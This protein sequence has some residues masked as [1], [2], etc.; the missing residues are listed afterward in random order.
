MADGKVFLGGAPGLSARLSGRR[1]SLLGFPGWVRAAA[2]LV[3]CGLI[4]TAG[5]GASATNTSQRLSTNQK[6]TVTISLFAGEPDNMVNVKTDLFT[7][8]VEKHFHIK[9]TFDLV[10]SADVATKQSLVLNSGS[11]PA[12]IW[13]GSIT[14]ENALQYGSERIFVPLNKLLKR[15]APN[16]WKS[17]QSVPGYKREVTAPN[18]QIY[19]LPNVNYCLYCQYG[20]H[21]WVNIKYLQ[22][23]GLSMPKTTAQ[24][25]NMLKVFKSHGLT[26]ITGSP[27]MWNG[28]TTA[29]LMNAFIPY[30]ADGNYFDVNDGKLIFVPTQPQWRAGL[31]YIHSLYAKGYFS[32]TALT[33]PLAAVQE[34]EAKQ[35]V[36]VIPAGADDDFVNNFGQ[37]GTHSGD[38][39]TIP[40]LTGP[41]GVRSAAL[42]GEFE[43]GGLT[44][45]ITNK[46]TKAQEV[47]I[48]KLLNFMYTPVGAEMYTFGPEG[49]YWSYASKGEKGLF[50]ESALFKSSDSNF[51]NGAL[52]NASWYAWG[53]Y[54]ESA[55]W[56]YRTYTPKTLGVMGSSGAPM[57]A[58]EIGAI[59]LQSPEQYPIVW[60]P[61][62]ESEQ[63]DTEQ[64]NIDNYVGEWQAYFET[65]E[66]SLTSSWGQYL[67]G[68]KALGLAS[69]LKVAKQV[70]GAPM[71]TS[72][73]MLYQKDPAEI[74]YLICSG[75]VSSLAK[76]YLMQSGV[77]A[78][79]FNCKG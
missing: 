7:K 38:W 9:F 63:Y 57:L 70:M 75:P 42:S 64:T 56:R 30:Q 10:P 5:G 4:I 51:A 23:F 31:E 2:G 69:Y 43:V 53:P 58:T 28:D 39:L 46:A 48:M 3:V 45:A 44:F 36:G 65:G 68:L 22:E 52:Q 61:R 60:I 32:K 76:K 73:G 16:V 55:T 12:V 20:V 79:D 1:R 72:K 35:K 37:P 6:G 54:D 8:Y 34:L 18:G 78:K 74:H 24:F 33:Q 25:A 50:P 47:R 40:A 71:Q 15:Y 26:P 19:A 41:K 66:K 62:S 21:D 27:D 14:Q 59:G 17:I 29:F 77:P 49:K 67:A 11:Y 13:G